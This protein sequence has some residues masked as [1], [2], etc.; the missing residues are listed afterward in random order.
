MSQRWAGLS[1]DGSVVTPE[2]G[3]W[4]FS[5]DCFLVIVRFPE[6][7]CENILPESML[8]LEIQGGA[9]C[10]T[11]GSSMKLQKLVWSY[12]A[13][14]TCSRRRQARTPVPSTEKNVSAWHCSLGAILHGDPEEAM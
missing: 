7:V 1:G 11:H 6:L 13:V 8:Y 2:T 4:L 12:E 9:T 3:R 10:S 14:A 5:R